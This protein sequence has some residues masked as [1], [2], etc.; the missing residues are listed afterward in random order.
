MARIPFGFFARIILLTTS[1]VLGI[2][3]LTTQ[4]AGREI[5]LAAG[6][7]AGAMLATMIRKRKSSA[8]GENHNGRKLPH[9]TKSH[10]IQQAHF[11]RGSSHFSRGSS[12]F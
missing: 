7:I 1:S 3:S 10:T 9:H 6:S 4:L 11:S 12:P 8:K 2:L 5:V